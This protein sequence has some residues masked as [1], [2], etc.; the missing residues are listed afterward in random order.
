MAKALEA[1]PSTTLPIKGDAKLSAVERL[2]IYANMYFFRIRDILKE[3]FPALLS[4]VG[5]ADFHQLI[6][7][8]LL[9]H[10]STH[11]S[12]RYAGKDL[13]TFVKDHR[14]GKLKLFLSELAEFEWRIL[15][16]FDAPDAAVLTKEKLARCSPQEWGGLKLSLVPSC[17]SATFTWNVDLLHAA[18]MAKKRKK[19]LPEQ[20]RSTV[21]IWRRELEVRQRRIDGVERDL[22]EKLTHGAT[23][24][25]ICEAA[26]IKCGDEA[27]IAQASSLLAGWL[28]AQLLCDLNV[29]SPL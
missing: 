12:L 23:F 8:Y 29:P 24:G 3:D 26:S 10:P 4:L 20:Q 6:T 22:F 19:R 2:D 9:A 17:S 11:W 13:A 18:F 15:E 14:L 16:A 25:E 21:I 5:E 1:D 27:G 7:D 28:E